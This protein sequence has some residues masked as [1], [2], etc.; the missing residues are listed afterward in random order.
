MGYSPSGIPI[1]TQPSDR[2]D[3]GVSAEPGELVSEVVSLWAPLSRPTV[4]GWG[5]SA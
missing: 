4:S 1:P 3:S 2:G 5:D